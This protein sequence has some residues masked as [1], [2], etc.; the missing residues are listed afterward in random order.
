MGWEEKGAG[1]S[2]SEW[3][4]LLSHRRAGEEG[5]EKEGLRQTNR[6]RAVQRW[7]DTM[8]QSER[9]E[10]EESVIDTLL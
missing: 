8:G 6:D 3:P 1:E 2:T 5:G 7:R 10:G 4:W 9:T